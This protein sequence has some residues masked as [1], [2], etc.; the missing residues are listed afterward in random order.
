MGACDDIV[1]EEYAP[2]PGDV[3]EHESGER[4]I[5]GDV[6]LAGGTCGCCEYGPFR[7]RR[8]GPEMQEVCRIAPGWRLLYNI[9]RIEVSDDEG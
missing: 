3:F 9:E 6:N 8:E 7:H 4:Q 5:V 1:Q 2:K